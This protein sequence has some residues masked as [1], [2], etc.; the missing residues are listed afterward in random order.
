MFCDLVGSTAMAARLDP[1]DLQAVIGGIS[2][3]PV[4]VRSLPAGQNLFAVSPR[5]H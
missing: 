5:D 3:H 4:P 1:E 2:L